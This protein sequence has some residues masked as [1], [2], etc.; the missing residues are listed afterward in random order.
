MDIC[1]DCGIINEP[2]ISR[3]VLEGLARTP[4]RH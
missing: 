2:D 3:A 4:T 1:I